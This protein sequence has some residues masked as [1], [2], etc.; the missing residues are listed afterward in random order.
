[1]ADPPPVDADDA[2]DDNVAAGRA[3]ADAARSVPGSRDDHDRRISIIEALLLALVAVLAAYS[4]F[5]SAKWGTE[6]RLL[7]ARGSTARTEAG[8]ARIEAM[9]SRNFDS[10]TFEA[11]FTAYT[12]GNDKAMELAARRFRP[13]F[14]SAFDAWMATN[15]E[16]NPASPPGPTYMPEYAQPKAD[17]AVR[18]TAD[19][20]RLYREGAEAGGN[21]DGYVRTTVYLATVLFLVGISG[22][23]RVR[24]ARIGL[25]VIGSSLLAYSTVLLLVAPRPP[26]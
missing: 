19:A 21:A 1:M 5:S 4:G 11:W 7:L 20:D 26:T 23:F 15:P 17:E 2:I 3:E 6:S 8:A 22:H 10:S 14:R 25:V 24:P 12:A 13:E 18:L 9:D 16:Q